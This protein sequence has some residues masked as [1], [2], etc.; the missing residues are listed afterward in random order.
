MRNDD[1]YPLNADELNTND[2]IEAVVTLIDNKENRIRISVKRLEKQ[3]ER[4]VLDKIN[5]DDK[6]TLGDILKDKL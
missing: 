5:G 4:E 2:E 3:K 6:M 1:L